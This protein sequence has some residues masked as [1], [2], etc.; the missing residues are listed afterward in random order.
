MEASAALA[1]AEYMAQPALRME[2]EMAREEAPC[3]LRAHWRVL[4]RSS[5]SSHS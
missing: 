1:L 3:L 5:L 2:L 4:E